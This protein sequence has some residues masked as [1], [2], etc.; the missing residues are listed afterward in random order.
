MKKILSFLMAFV[1]LLSCFTC[2]FALTEEEQEIDFMVDKSGSTFRQMVQA[3]AHLDYFDSDSMNAPKLQLV[4]TDGQYKVECTYIPEYYVSYFMNNSY[5]TITDET[6]TVYVK[7]RIDGGEWVD[8]LYG[9]L[10]AIFTSQKSFDYIVTEPT[11]FTIIDLSKF[12]PDLTEG[13]YV[14][15]IEVKDD[16]YFIDLTKHTIEVRLHVV[17]TAD[18]GNHEMPMTPSTKLLELTEDTIPSTLPQPNVDRLV[19]SAAEN[20]MSC[21]VAQD[22]IITGLRQLGHDCY[23]LFRYK[24]N[25]G[26]TSEIQKVSCTNDAYT[27]FSL[28]KLKLLKDKT[29]SENKFVAEFAYYDETTDTTSQWI[30]FDAVITEESDRLAVIHAPNPD[31]TPK[32]PCGLCQACPAQPMGMCLWMFVGMTVFA[33]VSIVLAVVVFLDYKKRTPNTEKQ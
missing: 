22:P 29:L 5:H 4:N 23:V 25:G 14:D 28:G 6:M 27:K 1:L 32:H 30:S 2:A 24:L 9:P 7:L 31:V 26:K 13:P 11:T 19:V 12:R 3:A 17:Y 15:I 21:R 10:C 18:D 33:V 16:N 20:A 8:S